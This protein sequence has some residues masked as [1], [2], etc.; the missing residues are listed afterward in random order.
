MIARSASEVLLARL[1]GAPFRFDD[2]ASR[3]QADMFVT[4]GGLTR[5]APSL[6]PEAELVVA[7]QYADWP[8][9][10]RSLRASLCLSAIVFCATPVMVASA[11]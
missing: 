8:A 3:R 1:L 5:Y 4:G 11:V 6:P 2:E 9:A 10:V 7:R